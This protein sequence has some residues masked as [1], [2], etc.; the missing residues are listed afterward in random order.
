MGAIDYAAKHAKAHAKVLAA[1]FAI[2][3]SGETRSDYNP[4]TGASTLTITTVV[5]VAIRDKG[6]PK[7]Y[8]RLGLIESDAPTLLFVADT[9]FEVPELGMT[10]TMAGVK[11]TVRDVNPIAPGGSAIMT[12]LV[13]SV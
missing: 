3:W 4:E 9:A 1:G 2:T 12:K 8:D 5:G 6:D 10:G 11:Y 7:V 13:V